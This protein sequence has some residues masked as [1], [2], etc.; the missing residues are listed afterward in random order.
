MNIINSIYNNIFEKIKYNNK[1]LNIRFDDNFVINDDQITIEN[2]NIKN[3]DMY[4][5]ENSKYD[6][7][8]C[9]QLFTNMSD[10][11]IQHILEKLKDI[12]FSH[13]KIIFI[14]NIITNFN[15]YYYHPFSF[16]KI[17]GKSVYMEYMY[18]IIRDCNMNI[19]NTDRVYSYDLFTYPIETFI[20]ICIFKP[21]F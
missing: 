19:I 13:T 12:S 17:F 10:D 7:I 14:N 5:K 16:L 8:I 11:K 2:I 20:V 4:V 15:Q 21:N 18:D 9:N 6:V 1:I 3:Y